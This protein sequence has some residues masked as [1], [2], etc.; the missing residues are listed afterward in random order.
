VLVTGR[1]TLP[2]KDGLFHYSACASEPPESKS[3][4]PAAESAASAALR[5]ADGLAGCRLEV[6]C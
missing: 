1:L 2:R 6:W 3:Q 4:A 5:R